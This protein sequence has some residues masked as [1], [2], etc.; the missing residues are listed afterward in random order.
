VRQKP[1]RV[2]YALRQTS[3]NVKLM[4]IT[5]WCEHVRVKRGWCTAFCVFSDVHGSFFIPNSSASRGKAG[6]GALEA[7]GGKEKIYIG[8]HA[9]KRTI[10]RIEDDASPRRGCGLSTIEG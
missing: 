9:R 7:K 8:D 6:F 1:V 5:R 10:Y 3:W 4:F 2:T